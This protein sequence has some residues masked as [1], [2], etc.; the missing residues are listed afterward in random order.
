MP[1]FFVMQEGGLLYEPADKVCSS[2]SDTIFA[3]IEVAP[4]FKDLQQML[5]RISD[6]HASKL[7]LFGEG[8]QDPAERTSKLDN[9]HAPF[10]PVLYPPAPP[11]AISWSE[12][13]LKA[14]ML[15]ATCLPNRRIPTQIL[16]H[17]FSPLILGPAYS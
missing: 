1:F 7:N 8:T 10:A 4:E 15:A 17:C 16:K 5:T 11:P 3:G 12:S 2:V 6:Q 13:G 9:M 14:A